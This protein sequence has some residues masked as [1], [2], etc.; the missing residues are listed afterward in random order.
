MLQVH[1]IFFLSRVSHL[2][3]ESQFLHWRTVLR[4][5]DL[6]TRQALDCSC[7]VPKSDSL[8]PHGLKPTRP[9]PPWDSPG[10]NAGEGCHFLLQGIFPTQGLNSC[11]G[12]QILY[13]WATRELLR[14]PVTWFNK[15]I[16]LCILIKKKKKTTNP[17][18]R[19]TGHKWMQLEGT[20]LDPAP[21]LTSGLLQDGSSVRTI[22]SVINSQPG[23]QPTPSNEGSL[24]TYSCPRWTLP[25]IIALTHETAVSCWKTGWWEFSK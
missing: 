23:T 2:S 12:R 11:I 10:K 18:L 16:N 5:Q 21:R 13:Y 7:L 22:N 4:N 24:S 15:E 8:W 20:C 3:K 1:L 6:G 19:A 14:G 17:F 9:L 25:I